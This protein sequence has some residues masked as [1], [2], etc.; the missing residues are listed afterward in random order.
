[1]THKTQ[2]KQSVSLWLQ[3]QMTWG[4]LDGSSFDSEV[5]KTKLIVSNKSN[6]MLVW[7]IDNYS[8]SP[9]GPR[10][11]IHRDKK[12]LE[13]WISLHYF[14]LAYTMYHC[15][16]K[17]WQK[18]TKQYVYLYICYFWNFWHTVFWYG[19]I[20]SNSKSVA[21]LVPYLIWLGSLHK[22]F[23]YTR[24]KRTLISDWLIIGTSPIFGLSV[25]NRNQ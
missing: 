24:H 17:K 2:Q 19:T 15:N 23:V 7:V 18:K 5:S 14:V 6:F 22:K 11:S 3:E 1:V 16:N 13:R 9:F 21:E 12:H 25:E 8:I 20:K 10:I 4:S